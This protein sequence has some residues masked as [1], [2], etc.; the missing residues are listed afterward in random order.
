M[1]VIHGLPLEHHAGNQRQA[2]GN[3]ALL[4]SPSSQVKRLKT[5]Y[6]EGTC[7]IPQRLLE[8]LVFVLLRCSITTPRIQDT[9]WRHNYEYQ[10]PCNS[11]NATFVL[12]SVTVESPHTGVSLGCMLPFLAGASSQHGGSTTCMSPIQRVETRAATAHLSHFPLP[13]SNQAS[14]QAGGS[15]CGCRDN[16]GLGHSGRGLCKR[17]SCTSAGGISPQVRVGR[18][19]LAPMKFAWGQVSAP[20]K[21][22]QLGSRGAI[23]ATS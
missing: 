13:G 22:R 2:G 20:G 7:C 3:K 5:R 1:L 17:E 9:K 6:G 8:L 15:C 11:A 19:L 14:V 10:H 12:L 16:R 18:R 21:N 4:H 23:R